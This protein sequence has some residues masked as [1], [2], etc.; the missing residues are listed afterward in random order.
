M[1]RLLPSFHAHL[2]VFLFGSMGVVVVVWN[3]YRQA[4]TDDCLLDTLDIPALEAER[5]AFCRNT[6]EANLTQRPLES[7]LTS[8]HAL[9]CAGRLD[10]HR[11]RLQYPRCAE[12]LLLGKRAN[13]LMEGIGNMNLSDPN[14]PEQ[15]LLEEIAADA[16]QL[17]RAAM[18]RHYFDGAWLFAAARDCIPLRLVALQSAALLMLCVWKK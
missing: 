1:L 11:I 10:I 7:V 17:T 4:Q 13:T 6:E 15:L 5:V 16:R 9:A 8:M 18:R 3:L 14:L 2:D 12:L